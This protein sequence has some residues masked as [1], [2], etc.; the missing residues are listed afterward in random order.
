MLVL[1]NAW[2]EAPGLTGAKAQ[3]PAY[4]GD[5]NNLMIIWRASIVAAVVLKD[6]CKYLVPIF[7]HR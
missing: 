2:F 1:G 4:L 7:C 3:A 5:A 6:V